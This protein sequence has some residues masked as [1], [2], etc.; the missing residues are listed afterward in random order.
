MAVRAFALLLTLAAVF[1]LRASAGSLDLDG[2]GQVMGTKDD[3]I[4]WLFPNYR[5]VDQEKSQPVITRREKLSIALNDSFDP[6]AF[7]VAGIF[8]GIAQL[9]DRP[10]A[11]DRGLD[12]YRKRFLA[13]FADQTISNLMAEGIFP[14]ALKQDPRYLRLG[15]GGFWH[16]AGYAL[17]RIFVTRTDAGERQ[18]NYSELGGNAVMAGTS[19]LYRPRADRTI[20]NA[21]QT[22]GLQLAMDSVGNVGK[23]FWPDVKAWLT[24]RPSP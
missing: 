4:L 16:R 18:F 17:T 2:D 10:D 12:G 6:Y 24:G 9:E 23:E 19:I 3:R 7:P 14:I 15:R 22:L 8:A 20:G 1:P 21:S 13:A 5:T 11:W